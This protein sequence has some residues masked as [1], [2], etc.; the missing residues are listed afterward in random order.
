PVAVGASQLVLFPNPALG[1]QPALGRVTLP[2][3][4]GAGG[5]IV[6][7]ASTNPAAAAVPATVM[8]PA[9]ASSATF[10]ITTLSVTVPTPVLISTSGNFGAASAV[11]QV[12]PL[13]APPAAAGPNLLVNGSFEQ[14]PVPAGQA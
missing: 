1:G 4:A 14:P 8:V 6:P 2:Q 5:E 7:L 9:G 10:V 3:P 11:L 12:L 13:P